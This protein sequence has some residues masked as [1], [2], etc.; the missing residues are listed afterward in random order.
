MFA[1]FHKTKV[2][3]NETI[4]KLD[5]KLL[6]WQQKITVYF[7]RV[8][9]I[10][11]K[12]FGEHLLPVRATALAYT[13]LLSLIPLLAVSLSLFKAFGGMEKMKEPI[14]DFILKNLATGA[15][16]T[17]VEYIGSF[18]DSYQSATI[19][20]VGFLF[21]TLTVVALLT[22]I[23]KTFNHIWGITKHRAFIPRFTVYWSIITIGPVLLGI[24]LS[25]T[26][27]L[28]SHKLVHEVLALSGM[29]HFLVAK[30]PWLITFVMFTAMYMIMPNTKVKFRSA[31]VGGIIGGALWELAKIGYTI[32]VAKVVNY[33]KIYGS[34][35][36]I[37]ILLIWIYYT[38][39]VV[40]IG[41]ELSFADQHFNTYR[42]KQR[43]VA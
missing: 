17:A 28:Q 2:Y 25:V 12:G 40:L 20:L 23:E 8:I 27:A 18:I 16:N 37:P 4:W 7:L 21:L 43:E 5:W 32:Y 13:T 34:L 41:A 22:T 42:L 33:S 3:C 19:G 30:I 36:M 24:S 26:S 39:V 29:E 35:G 10:I 6:S 15:G 31:L 14:Q 1:V 11:V 9:S 38:W